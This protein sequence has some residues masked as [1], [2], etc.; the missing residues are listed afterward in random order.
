ML[1]KYK[2][3]NAIR[4][5]V[6]DNYLRFLLGDCQNKVWRLCEVGQ[7][8]CAPIQKSVHHIFERDLPCRESKQ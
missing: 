3:F 1:A 6:S 8:S 5:Q 7:W 2:H 4:E